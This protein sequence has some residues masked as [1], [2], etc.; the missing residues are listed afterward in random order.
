MEAIRQNRRGGAALMLSLWALFLLSAMVISWA[1]EIG[2]RLNMSGNANRNL[3]A[4]ALACSGVEVAQHPLAKPGSPALVGGFGRNQ[5]FEARITGEGGRL[6]IGWLIKGEEPAKI[7]VL[8]KFLEIKGIDLNER[9]RMIDTLLDWVDADNL[10]RL[11][12]AEEEAGYKA[13]NKMFT[14][15]EELK[16]VMGW[17]EFTSNEN[18][19]SD[20]TLDSQ[21]GTINLAWASRDVLLSLPGADEMRVDQFL[22]MRPGGDGIDGNDDDMF[23]KIDEALSVLG[24][25]QLGALV[26]FTRDDP[27]QRI[28][29]IGESG[30]VTRKVQAVFQK[31]GN[32]IQQKSWKEY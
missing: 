13:A 20:L 1:L 26:S 5:R 4:Q 17:E 10:V 31:S 19:D 15:L 3:E 18:W 2:A 23:T 27:I 32:S 30:T 9:D 16:K 7:E 29:S 28:V 14:R 12:G 22:T 11:N 21:P 25:P 8:R 24:I 6:N